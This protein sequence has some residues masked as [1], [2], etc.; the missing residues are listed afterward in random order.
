MGR[1]GVTDRKHHVI[2]GAGGGQRVAGRVPR[3]LAPGATVIGFKVSL[4][5]VLRGRPGLEEQ[6]DLFRGYRLELATSAADLTGTNPVQSL[7]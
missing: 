6:D 2:E 4:W 5:P 1:G 7:N 3:Q